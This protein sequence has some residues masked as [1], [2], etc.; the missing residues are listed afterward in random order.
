MDRWM[1]ESCQIF[2]SSGLVVSKAIYAKYMIK[3]LFSGSNKNSENL[4]KYPTFE[5]SFTML[6][7]S[8]QIQN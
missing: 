8:K 7:W 3:I 6:P 2:V 5:V 4:L 1:D